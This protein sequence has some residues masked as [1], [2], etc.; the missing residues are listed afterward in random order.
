MDEIGN[1]IVTNS[2]HVVPPEPEKPIITPE[3]EPAVYIPTQTGDF[4]DLLT[5]VVVSSVVCVFCFVVVRLSVKIKNRR[6]KK[7]N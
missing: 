4:N 6:S 2:K 7:V 5:L 3:P 1:T